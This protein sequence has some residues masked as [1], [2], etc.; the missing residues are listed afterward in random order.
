MRFE[1]QW[2]SVCGL[3]LIV[4]L[5]SANGCA[6][7][8][9]PHEQYSAVLAAATPISTNDLQAIENAT[10]LPL[11]P[12]RIL[13]TRITTDDPRIEKNDVQANYKIFEI[14]GNANT[15]YT[16]ELR[17]LC[18][19]WGLD[20]FI[21]YPI[22]RI[23]DRYGSIINEEFVDISLRDADWNHPVNIRLVMEGEFKKND[24]HYLLVSA[25]NDNVGAS[26]LT[27]AE[28]DFLASQ[29]QRLPPATA[30]LR[31]LN[32]VGNR[33]GEIR[34]PSV[35]PLWSSPT[36]KIAVTLTVRPE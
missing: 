6:A 9:T 22:A 11:Q 19:C 12:D 25:Y 34:D 35:H 16:I 10:A 15:R 1:N 23:L 32:S 17:S 5:S 27:F 21:L 30:Y 29:I 2:L 8:R 3:A 31:L 36:G 13:E 28:F 33:S 20:K 14:Q 24:T 26:Y 18:D 4:L 7:T